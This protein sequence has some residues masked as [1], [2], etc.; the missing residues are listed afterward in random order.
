MRGNER[1]DGM[2]EHQPD[3]IE[4]TER[5]YENP[6]DS[7]IDAERMATDGWT[8]VSQTERELKQGCMTKVAGLIVRSKDP[9]V[10]YVVTYQRS[11]QSTAPPE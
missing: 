3:G 5:V 11:V 7:T 6:N 2:A 4:T 9:K 10:Q 1:G 8:V